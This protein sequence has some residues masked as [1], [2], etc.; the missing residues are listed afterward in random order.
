MYPSRWVRVSIHDFYLSLYAYCS[1]PH[2]L[3]TEAGRRVLVNA[4]LLH[5]VSNISDAEVDVG[6][7]PEFQMESTRFEYAATSY[8]DVVNFMIVKGPPA[9]ISKYWYLNSD[10]I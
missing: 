9:S 5:I 1:T 7:I 6:I 3:Q 10:F 2:Q 8:G 4:I